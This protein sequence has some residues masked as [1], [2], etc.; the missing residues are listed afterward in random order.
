MSSIIKVSNSEYHANRTHLSS[1]MLK[2]LLKDPQEFYRQWVLGE[3]PVEDKPA[4]VEGSL[5]H[6]LCLEPEKLDD[7]AVFQ[8]LRRKGQVWDEFQ[9]ANKSKTIV[10]QAQLLRA[11]RYREACFNKKSASQLLSEGHAEFTMHSELLNVPVKA[12]A[13]YINWPKQYIVDIKTTSQPSDIE[14]FKYTCSEYGYD[15]SAALY[16]A[17][18]SNVF[19]HPFDFYWIVISKVDFTCEVYKASAV[20]LAKGTEA[21]MSALTLY[22]RCSVSGIWT[23]E[24]LK[25]ERTDEE[26]L[27]V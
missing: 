17:I 12:R 9:A 2:L 21:Y 8:G 16:C 18:A 3:K 19:G 22:K 4:F 10:T 13:D 14:L 15:L 27:E 5:T 7:Y 23:H 1:S 20:T 26:I 11:E 6:T 24:K 25:T